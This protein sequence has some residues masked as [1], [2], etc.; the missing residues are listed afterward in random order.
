MS[1]TTRTV[2]DAPSARR[3]VAQQASLGAEWVSVGPSTGADVVRAIVAAARAGRLQVSAEPGA[4]AIADL[5]RMGVDA[6]DR[7]GFYTRS[8]EDRENELKA[9]PDF[10]AGDRDAALDYLWRSAGPADLRPVIPKGLRRTPTLIPLLGSFNGTLDAEELKADPAVA[11]LPARWREALIAR[12]H[13]PGWPRGTAAAAAADARSRLV[14]ALFSAG[15]RLATGVDAEST[16]YTVPGA[17]VHRELSLLVKAGLSPADAIRAA[18][19]N[20]AEMLG[21]GTTLGEI[22]AGFKADLF[23]VEGDPLAKVEDLRR[24]RLVVRGGEALDPADLL[25]Q[26]RRAAR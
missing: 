11:V 10:P 2:G 20:C 8:V 4:T 21:T 7:V 26:A 15:V 17:G 9:R 18:T 13:L 16:G 12:A 19:I 6:V 1:F 5:L 22:R 25:A 23:A 24:I 14:K 3:E